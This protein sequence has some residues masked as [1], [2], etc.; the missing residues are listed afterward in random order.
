MRRRHQHDGPAQP[1]RLS[2]V[3]EAL[4]ALMQKKIYGPSTNHHHRTYFAQ[5]HENVL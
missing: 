1:G 5:R 2:I 4:T 3:G